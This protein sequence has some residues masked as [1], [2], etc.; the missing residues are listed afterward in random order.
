MAISS[1]SSGMTVTTAGWERVNLFAIPLI[2]VVL[3]ALAWY[4]FTQRGRKPAAA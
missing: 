3:M 1:L 2:G 4:A